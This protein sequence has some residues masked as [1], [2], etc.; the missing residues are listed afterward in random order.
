MPYT[1]G[2]REA[3]SF[4]PEQQRRI[5]QV[6]LARVAPE[7]RCPLCRHNDWA[8]A[9]G[10][11]RLA[12]GQPFAGWAATGSEI[13]SVAIICEHCGNTLILNA[14][15]LGLGDLFAIVTPLA[16]PALAGGSR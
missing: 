6:I 13:P 8:V 10:P 4:T 14:L 11:V 1:P 2:L 7:G 15:V 5:K 3:L 12:V 16:A 9:E